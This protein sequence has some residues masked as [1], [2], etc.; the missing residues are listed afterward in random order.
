M[1]STSCRPLYMGEDFFRKGTDI[2]Q[3]KFPVP[4]LANEDHVQ[5]AIKALL[6]GNLSPNLTFSLDSHIPWRVGGSAMVVAAGSMTSSALPFFPGIILYDSKYA[7]RAKKLGSQLSDTSA[8]K[9][10]LRLLID[11]PGPPVAKLLTTALASMPKSALLVA[12]HIRRGDGIMAQE[13]GR[14]ADGCVGTQQGFDNDERVHDDSVMAMLK[15]AKRQIVA[16]IRARRE[17]NVFIASDTASMLE[18]AKTIFPG[19]VLWVDGV[20]H[21][22]TQGGKANYAKIAADFFGMAMADVCIRS[23]SAFGGSAMELGG[24]IDFT[25][26]HNEYWWSPGLGR[27][28]EPLNPTNLEKLIAL[29]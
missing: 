3:I 20:A 19:D 23:R 7:D 29:R 14:G 17:V 9:C 22:T 26:E 16:K 24:C 18:L 21:H 5:P 2:D 12:I 1:N 11:T 28:D 8:V 13:C 6:N 25:Y 4:I 10:P 15:A 27:T